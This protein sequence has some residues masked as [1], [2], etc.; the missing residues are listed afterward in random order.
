[1]SHGESESLLGIKGMA[2]GPANN[3]SAFHNQ[4]HR[5]NLC[6]A[7][8]GKT[9]QLALNSEAMDEWCNSLGVGCCLDNDGGTA[10]LVELFSWVARLG[11]D[12]V[13]LNCDEVALLNVHLA[14]AVKDSDASAKKRSSLGRIELL[15][16]TNNSF[17]A[18]KDILGKSTILTDTIDGLV[19]AHLKL[20]PLALSTSSIMTTVPG[21]TNAV[22]VL[23]VGNTLTNLNYVADDFMARN[24]RENVAH[25]ASADSYVRETDTAGEDFDENLAIGGVLEGHVAELPG[26]IGL[27]EDAGLVGLGKGRHYF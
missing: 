25:V 11:V 20:G 23:E 26:G 17:R 19:I 1:M 22:A 4:R 14:N 3:A 18:K 5:I 24:S 13:T 27:V 16:N 10:E 15:G 2:T 7:C 8:R 21:S 12:V 9:K 6:R